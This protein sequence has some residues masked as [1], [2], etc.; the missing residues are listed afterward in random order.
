VT[1]LIYSHH[2]VSVNLN[3]AIF[4]L[5]VDGSN[6]TGCFDLLCPGFVQTTNE[7]ALGGVIR[8][9]PVPGGL[10]WIMTLYIVKVRRHRTS[11]L[12]KWVC[13]SGAEKKRKENTSVPM[14]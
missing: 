8:S 2:C 5:Q 1:L 11:F 3:Q 4:F 9:I 10:P 6:T 14:L 12:S 13:R 7:I